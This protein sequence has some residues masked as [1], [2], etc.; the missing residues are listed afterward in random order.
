M[1]LEILLLLLLGI[2]SNALQ[3]HGHGLRA[4]AMRLHDSTECYV[5]PCQSFEEMIAGVENEELGL[6]V[7]VGQSTLG[8]GAAGLGVFVAISDGVE[9]T[10]IK[11]GQPL[12][13]YS[14]GTFINTAEAAGDKTVAWL[15]SGVDQAIF[16][17]K[18]LMTL[19]D[20]MGIISDRHNQEDMSGSVLGHTLY[21]DEETDYL[22][23]CADESFTKRYFVPYEVAARLADGIDVEG[24]KDKGVAPEDIYYGIEASNMGMYCNDLAYYPGID[25]DTYVKTSDQ[26]N[27]LAIVWRLEDQDGVL[28]PTWPVVVTKQNI[29]F[30]NRD[31]CFEVGLQYSWKYWHAHELKQQEE[32]EEEDQDQNQ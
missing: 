2:L 5:G 20:A 16:F 22:G 29:T 28:Y 18:E 8:D 25:E 12:I 27:V 3:F 7:M 17:E 11:Q 26:K 6:S 24:A 1:C 15:F 13:G 21:L 19:R 14:K 23:V 9:E 4:R 31:E 32:E 10:S 30:N